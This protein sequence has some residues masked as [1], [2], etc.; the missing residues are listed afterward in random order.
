MRNARRVVRIDFQSL[1]TVSSVRIHPFGEDFF[2]AE[3]AKDDAEGRRGVIF[4]ALLCEN[5]CVL[6][7]E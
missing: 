1:L 5:L 4:F 3:D 6:C 7:V 2:S